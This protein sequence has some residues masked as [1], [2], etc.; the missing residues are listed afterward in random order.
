MKAITVWTEKGGVGKTL[1]TYNLGCLLAKGKV[2]DENTGEER[3]R[4]VLLIDSDPQGNLSRCIKFDCT[5]ESPTIYHFYEAK[6]KK[7]VYFHPDELIIKGLVPELPSLHLFGSHPLLHETEV[8][9]AREISRET[10]LRRYMQRFKDFFDT[11]DVILFDTNPSISVI[12]QNAL[13]ASDYVLFP[14]DISQNALD[15]VISSINF[16]RKINENLALECK[17]AGIIINNYD[18]RNKYSLDLVNYIKGNEILSPL[19]LENFV[20]HSVTFKRSEANG[21]VCLTD[22]TGKETTALSKIIDELIEKG[23]IS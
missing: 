2:K 17:I 1:M 8:D 19:L 11:Y 18:K 20:P 14:C 3:A 10:F 13:A 23:V 9:L 15:G 12:N 4:R 6:M 22:P 21:P 16:V 5:D 7:D